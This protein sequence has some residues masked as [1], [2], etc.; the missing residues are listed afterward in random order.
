MRNRKFTATVAVH[1]TATSPEDAE[2]LVAT[3]LSTAKHQ[4]LA[5]YGRTIVATITN[6]SLIKVRECEHALPKHDSE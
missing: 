3:F 6:A 1:V 4:C 2:Q 5:L